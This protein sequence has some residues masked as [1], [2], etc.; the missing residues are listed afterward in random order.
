MSTKWYFQFEYDALQQ[1]SSPVM[2]GSCQ[3]RENGSNYVY[4]TSMNEENLG[5][6]VES[7]F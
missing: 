3:A 2:I 5:S 7:C 6:K 1:S 4:Y